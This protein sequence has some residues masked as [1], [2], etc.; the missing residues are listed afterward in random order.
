VG[1]QER[2]GGQQNFGVVITQNYAHGQ[3]ALESAWLYADYEA[4]LEALP[5]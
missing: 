3:F 5:G 4:L 1:G 2:L